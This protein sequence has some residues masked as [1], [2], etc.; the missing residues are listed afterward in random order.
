MKKQFGITRKAVL[1]MSVVVLSITLVIAVYTY[2]HSKKLMRHQ[3]ERELSV[4]IEN[5]GYEV[6]S[7]FEQKG[8]I[9]R[10]LSIIPTIKKLATDNDSRESVRSNPSYQALQQVLSE[11]KEHNDNINLFWLTNLTHDYYITHDDQLSDDSF[12][13]K[14]RPWFVDLNQTGIRYS[15]P[16]IDIATEQPV[17]SITHPVI[18]DKEPAVYIGVDVQL[19]DLPTLLNRFERNG[20]QVILISEDNQ[21]L[22]DKN[23]MWDRL[24]KE[25]GNEEKITQFSTAS[26]IY[27][28]D[29]QEIENLNWKIALYV[30]EDIFLA[31]LKK[32]QSSLIT[33]W[34]IS[35]LILLSTLS[36]VLR[37]LLRDFPLITKQLKK[38]ENGDFNARIGIERSDEVGEISRSVDQ[39]AQK[40]QEQIDEM[41]YQAHFDSLTQLPNRYSI[42][43]TLEEWLHS[44]KDKNVIFIAV[45]FFDLDHFK[46]VNDSKGH[47]YGDELLFKVGQRVKKL[48]PSNCFFGR[49]GGDEFILLLRG[50]REKINAIQDTLT[51]IHTSFDDS[52]QLFEQSI[53]ITTSMGVALFPEDAK[54]KK[55]L[56]ANADTALYEA[57][58]AGRNLVYF[59]NEVM[60]ENF[61]K[62]FT[63]QKG[64][65]AALTNNEF[66]LHYQP[67]F[68]IRY[69]KVNSIEALLR[70]QHPEW[71][72]V[73]PA[74]FIPLAEKTGQIIEIGDWVID[75]SLQAIKRI[76]QENSDIQR[77]AIN[78]SAIQLREPD[79]VYKLEEAL[80]KH[81]VSPHFIEIEI[82][83]SVVIVDEK[84]AFQKLE[85]LKDLGIQIAL[86][87]F[88]TG[89][90]SLN[91]L[92]RMTIDKVK[93]DRSF[94]QQVEENDNVFAIL[95]MIIQLGHALGLEIIAEGV[96]TKAQL[97][98]LK[99]MNVDS[100]QGFY[101]SRPLDEDSLLNYFKLKH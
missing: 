85:D 101:Y 65:R 37:Y 96:E 35:L 82:T 6:T 16:Y 14:E 92:H 53:H 49:F 91:H 46:N 26:N 99:E 74:D 68:D 69:G 98:L 89:Y 18:I 1:T 95:K 83:E 86:D 28:A 66:R 29:T 51:T 22:Y 31:P 40:I 94:I 62:S 79:F 78:V 100:I 59:F 19:R 38:I 70:W 3:I 97:Q 50:K 72:M 21:V 63:L 47:A 5:I 90:S 33:F 80:L 45:V 27:Y 56:F 9:V 55:E 77:I 84:E 23:K 71:G 32:Y 17:V 76:M 67:Q 15:P 44:A 13:M 30:E 57:K 36:L 54:T 10:Q 81:Q 43:S 34:I 39:M 75:T 73:S 48:L 2:N 58:E 12:K 88:G 7:F 25:I 52:F 24:Q 42:E 60:K 8:E 93:I 87:D 20:H 11:A 4:E 64:L 61:E 41:N